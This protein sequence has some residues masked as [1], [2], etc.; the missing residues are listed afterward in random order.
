MDYKKKY[1]EAIYLLKELRPKISDYYREKLDGLF[2]ELAESEDE[3]IRKRIYNYI[4]VTLDDNESAEKEKWLAWLEKQGKKQDE[5]KSFDCENANIQQ[6]DLAPK[7]EPRFKV[8]DWVAANIYGLRSPLKIVDISDTEYRIE[9]V[10][11]NSGVPKIDYLD[12]H[13]H[14]WTADDAKDGDVMVTVA[15]H[16]PFIFKG[17]L[18]AKHPFAPVAYCGLEKWNVFYISSDPNWWTDDSFIPASPQER[19]QLLNAMHENGYEWD[20]DKKE[21]KIIDWSKHIK[22]EPDGPSIIKE[23]TA[24]ETESDI[25]IHPKFKVGDKIVI[26]DVIGEVEIAEITNG[27]YGTVTQFGNHLFFDINVLDR[28]AHYATK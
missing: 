19:E 1:K 23:K 2:P 11:G 25:N 10:K 21:L 9:D 16:K 3:R 14:L 17:F 8:G 20:P 28:E 22:Y 26:K 18:D 6:K 13:Y 4:N 5:Q 24:D 7:A 12:S 27:M 15:E